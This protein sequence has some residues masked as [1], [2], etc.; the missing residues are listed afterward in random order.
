MKQFRKQLIHLNWNPIDV[1][2]GL[3]DQ[4]VVLDWS[5]SRRRVVI[6]NKEGEL[7]KSFG[8][9]GFQNGQFNGPWGVEVDE[10]GRIIV[11][12]T[13]NNRIQVF[14]DALKSEFTEYSL[15]QT[16]LIHT[17]NIRTF[18][19]LSLKLQCNCHIAIVV[20]MPLEHK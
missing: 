12:D 9:H 5:K 6:L 2:I 7:I 14:D 15:R 16:M 10:E 20:T 4:I 18:T 19:E 3:N 1:S 17:F 13:F 11:A 8:S